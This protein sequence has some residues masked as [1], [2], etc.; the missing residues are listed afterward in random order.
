M[1]APGSQQRGG[2]ARSK[3]I[4]D[5]L[6]TRSDGESAW[7]TL[8]PSMDEF[9]LFKR[10]SPSVVALKPTRHIHRPELPRGDLSA[11]PPY[12]LQDVVVSDLNP[13]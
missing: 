3:H 8:N 11:G 4:F 7:L 13:P 5:L 1:T 6:S 2:L 12:L 10:H 9:N